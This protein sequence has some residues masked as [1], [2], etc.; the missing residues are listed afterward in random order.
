[1]GRDN[2]G[3]TI[4]PADIIFQST[5]PAWGETIGGYGELYVL[6]I[7]IHSPRMGRDRCPQAGRCIRGY[8][9]PLSPHGERLFSMLYRQLSK[10]FQSTLPAWGETA[11]ACRPRL[12]PVNFNPLSPHGERPQRLHP[13]LR[14]SD[15]NPLSPHGERPVSNLMQTGLSIS[16]HSPRMGRDTAISARAAEYQDFNP[17]SP[18]GERRMV[19]DHSAMHG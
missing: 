7:S 6:A 15:F 19:T 14:R 2:Y 8:F 4:R 16:I 13:Q 12:S 18:H 9:N 11:A 1:M 10:L 5:L 17:L 3:I